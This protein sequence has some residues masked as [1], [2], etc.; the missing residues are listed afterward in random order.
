MLKVLTLNIWHDAGPWTRRLSAIREGIQALK[1]NLIGLQEV[2]CM[3]D[4][5]QHEEIADGLGYFTT[6][7]QASVTRGT[8]GFGNAILSKWP[9]L[10]QRS[11]ALPTE[12]GDE[13]RGALVVLIDSPRG[14]ISVVCTHFSYR[15]EQGAIRL[16]QVAALQREVASHCAP[17]LVMGD[18]NAAPETPEISA[19][20]GWTD[21]FAACG[22]GEGTTF[23]PGTNPHARHLEEPERR[24]DYI[25]TVGESLTPMDCRV[26]LNHE[27][28]GVYPSDHFGVWAEIQDQ[29]N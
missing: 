13:T 9:I 18:F 22:V 12:P 20:D 23:S 4:L 14:P 2:L 19:I 7:G 15:F 1:P 5:R 3:A 10:E 16:E 28:Q 25:F 11:L 26:V 8:A 6:F 17:T 24:I 27:I 21:A 29:R